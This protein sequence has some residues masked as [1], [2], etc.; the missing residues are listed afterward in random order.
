MFDFKSNVV[1][2]TH[3]IVWINS[4]Y[5][6][7]RGT[8]PFIIDIINGEE[9]F[10]TKEKETI[11]DEDGNKLEEE[12]VFER[13]NEENK[14]Q[15]ESKVDKYIPETE[16]GEELPSFHFSRELKG[17]ADYNNLG[18]KELSN[19]CFLIGSKVKTMINVDDEPKTF[20]EAW[21]HEDPI[22]REAWRKAI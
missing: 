21:W 10:K 7:E 16:K 9:I 6:E 18:R 5:N 1:Y 12:I 11:E 8:K 2:L 19:F 22:E 17:L 15:E 3:D 4:S 13:D 14:D 20:Q